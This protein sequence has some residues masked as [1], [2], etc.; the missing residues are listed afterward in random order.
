MNSCTRST[1]FWL[2]AGSMILA[3]QSGN[4]QALAQD[5]VEPQRT[6]L[7]VSPA[8]VPNPPL[9]YRLLP[10]YGERKPGNAAVFYGKV[11]AEES[12]AYGFAGDYVKGMLAL[13]ELTARERMA[14]PDL[15]NYAQAPGYYMM[16][17]GALC[18]DCDWQ[19]PL[20]EEN[21]IM[22]LLPEVQQT[23]TFQRYLA[24]QTLAQIRDGNTDGAIETIQ[25]GNALARNVGKAPLLVNG[26]VAIAG[27]GMMRESLELLIEQPE[28]PS[29]YWAL[30]WLPE[31]FVDLRSAM[32]AESDVFL[33]AMPGFDQIDA[34]V[35]DTRFWSQ[36]YLRAMMALQAASRSWGQPESTELVNFLQMLAW[37]PQAKQILA[38][39]GM[40]PA[41][42]EQMPVGKV[43][44]LAE[45][46]D[47]LRNSQTLATI[48]AIPWWQL[49]A[50]QQK[51]T[52][53]DSVGL[54]S[55]FLPATAQVIRAHVRM[56]RTF[57]ALQTIEGIRHF[58]ATH[59][60]R[61]PETLDEMTETPAP[62]DPVSGK[63]FEY[64]REGN[65]FFIDGP[66]LE[67]HVPFGYEVHLRK[68][69]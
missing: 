9:K 65:T 6:V 34:P 31:P 49:T 50:E 8:K 26:L 55:Q 5:P 36:Q 27:A 48:A 60:G 1:L 10:G 19:I 47:F 59:D 24:L 69:K 63:P 51:A 45:R 12:R 3:L 13:L 21:A 38:E 41:E 25:T 68:Q 44:L 43:C 2:L 14:S 58:A 39:S 35:T 32:E 7:E 46:L 61:L 23:R 20:R 33:R 15:D 28:T 52:L 29:L 56:E 30:A 53:P 11:T 22:I 66:A 64:R 42:I 37:Y 67:P 54:T 4:S 57:N 62:L 18:D 17:A 16:R 40:N